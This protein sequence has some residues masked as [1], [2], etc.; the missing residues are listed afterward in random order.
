MPT[1]PYSTHVLIR[2]VS[3]VGAKRRKAR[4]RPMGQELDCDQTK[5][6][7]FNRYFMFKFTPDFYYFVARIIIINFVQITFQTFINS[8]I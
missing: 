3:H 6:Y 8:W 5:A 4:R 7:R 2:P 1:V